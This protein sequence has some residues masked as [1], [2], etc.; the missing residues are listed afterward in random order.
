[1][2]LCLFGLDFLAQNQIP[3]ELMRLGPNYPPSLSHWLIVEKPTRIIANA[4]LIHRP[5]IFVWRFNQSK[6]S[7]GHVE[8]VDAI[9]WI[10][11]T[12]AHQIWLGKMTH[13]P[14]FPSLPKTPESL[15]E[16]HI[17][18]S[19]SQSNVNSLWMQVFF[20]FA[21]AN[22][23]SWDRC[24]E[25]IPAN[26]QVFAAVNDATF[27]GTWYKLIQVLQKSSTIKNHQ[28]WER[29]Q[30]MHAVVVMLPKPQ[31]QGGVLESPATAPGLAEKTKT[32]WADPCAP[33]SGSGG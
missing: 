16:T 9:L 3:W 15:Q 29:N 24:Q 7:Q 19:Q 10:L 33:Q 27:I 23:Q 5:Y 6:L 20:Q 12:T 8:G 2:I 4:P 30:T 21:P 32:K 18:R 25:C 26:G 31:L 13:V 28:P 1:M 22:P 17:Q 11:A 14:H